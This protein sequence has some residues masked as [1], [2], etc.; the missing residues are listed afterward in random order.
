MSEVNVVTPPA[1]A[2]QVQPD[3][4]TQ[5]ASS[6]WNENFVAPAAPS[7]PAS[8]A[9]PE[10]PVVEESNKEN[11]ITVDANQWLKENFGWENPDAAKAEVERLRQ[12][13]QQAATPAEIKFANDE[14]RKYYEAITAGKSD[15][16]YNILHQQR[17]LTRLEQME[18]KS[19]AEASE[20]IKA[21]LQ[22]KYKDLSPQE[23]ERL[24]TRQYA[25]PEKPKQMGEDDTE[26][27]VVV[28]D[29]QQRVQ[30]R[31]QD[32]MIDARIA[33]PEL[34]KYKNELTLPDIPKVD[35]QPQGP[36][37]EELA[38]LQQYRNNF[39]QHFERDYAKFNGFTVTAKDGGV[40]LPVTY[41]VTPE[42]LA[43][44]KQSVLDTV[45]NI[46]Q[47]IEGR[48]FDDK[49]NPNINAIQED[50]YLLN[51][52]NKVLQKIAN[53]ASAQRAAH[54]LKER[55]NINLNGINNSGIQPNG[56]AAKSEMQ[57]V[58]EKVWNL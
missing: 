37:Q 16:I 47:F 18:I 2:E 41:S 28:A 34:L 25:L 43:A 50:L 8:A 3:V 12:L 38:A 58:A 17:Q 19:A 13:Q 29:W 20:I 33:K 14:A 35:P 27:A 36:S 52:R 5:L 22:F 48:W 46:N 49:G 4:N 42:E 56:V 10:A 54:E 40:D 30:E 15:D 39:T 45:F 24:Y 9:A 6:M 23:I 1:P 51:N 31:E 11:I 26:Y 55:N 32:I 7:T 44:S 57:Q 21:N 53:D